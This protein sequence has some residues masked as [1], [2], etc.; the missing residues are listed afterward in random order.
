MPP[1][2]GVNFAISNVVN[3]F[4]LSSAPSL[5]LDNLSAGAAYST[6]LNRTAYGISSPLVR[7]RRSNDNALADIPSKLYA[8]RAHPYWL[9]EDALLAHCGANSGFVE[10]WYDQSGNS[11]HI[12]QATQAAQPRIV[13]A[14]TIDTQNSVPTLVFDGIDDVLFNSSP[15]LYANGV[16]T[17]CFVMRAA[18]PSSP[19]RLWG[20]ASTT[21]SAFYIASG[22][23]TAGTNDDIMAAIRNDAGA[24]VLDVGLATRVLLADQFNNTLRALVWRD[25]GSSYD[26][27]GNN[28]QGTTQSYT[29]SGVLTLDRFAIGGLQRATLS[30]PIAASISEAIFFPQALSTTNRVAVNTS[31]AGAYG[32]T[33]NP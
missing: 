31:Q 12:T 2:F 33:L 30:S 18:A 28:T 19:R 10:T 22:G 29:R 27:F 23:P 17:A 6:R 11:R 3:S 7:V 21:T 8:A 13:N 15:W 4:R 16:M 5:I 14:G 26:G 25:T 9:D 32:I 24:E 1:S 20:E